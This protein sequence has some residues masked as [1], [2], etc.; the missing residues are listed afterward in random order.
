M[1]QPA[2]KGEGCTVTMV[3]PRVRKGHANEAGCNPGGGAPREWKDGRTKA[4]CEREPAT[5]DGAP[6]V[7]ARGEGVRVGPHANGRG[8]TPFLHPCAQLID[9]EK[10]DVIVYYQIYFYF[11]FS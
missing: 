11:S 7:H 8:R 6:H 5:G 10:F 4:G 3:P 9:L 2:E 1:V